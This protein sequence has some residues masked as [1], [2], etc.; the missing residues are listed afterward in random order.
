MRF[1]TA[2]LWASSGKSWKSTRTPRRSKIR[3]NS[4]DST[5]DWESLAPTSMYTPSGFVS[6][7]V[8]RYWLGVLARSAS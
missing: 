7:M 4:I 2:Q 5:R 3:C 1:H 6:G 8:G